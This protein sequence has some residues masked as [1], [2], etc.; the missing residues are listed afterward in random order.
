MATHYDIVHLTEV[1]TTQDE[2]SARFARSGIPTLVVADRQVAGRG[3]Q[4]RRWEQPDRAMF[5]SV[6]FGIDWDMAHRSLVP[7][8]TGLVVAEAINA[9]GGRQ[10]KVKW[11]NDLL[12]G[13][14][15]V[16]GVLVELDGDRMTVGS[17]LNLWWAAPIEGATSVYGDDPGPASAL[18]LAGRWVT[19][20]FGE[21]DQGAVAWRRSDYVRASAT[22]GREVW[23]DDG[24]GRAVSVTDEGALV[25]DTVAGVRTIHAG[26]VHMRGWR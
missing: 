22:L 18:G 25:V 21:L 10:T 16:G 20:L 13:K 2:A 8:V 24:E 1:A 12:V 5:A 3:R 4:G 6:S 11:P 19:A 23:W 17:G 9:A 26:D 15:K 14:A 7:L